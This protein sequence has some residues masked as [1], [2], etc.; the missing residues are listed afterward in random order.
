LFGHDGDALG[1][2]KMIEKID[3]AM[4]V[5]AKTKALICI[6]G[7]HST[8]CNIKDHSGDDVPILFYGEGMRKDDTP[9]YGEKYCSEFG[10]LKRIEGKDV[11]P[12]ILNL[13]GKQKVIE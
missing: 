10:A 3:E 8:P 9:A 6:T 13:I 1:K 4:Q 11:M 12:E 2:K 5:L 7:D